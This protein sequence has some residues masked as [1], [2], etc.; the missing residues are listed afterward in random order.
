MEFG[1]GQALPIYSGGLGILAGDVLKTASDLGVPVIGIGLLYQQGYFRQIIS[2]DG[3]QR[4]FYPYNDPIQLPV[5][6][7]R[8]E[9]GEWLR[10]KLKYPGRS[11][12][13][14]TW[15]AKVGRVK[16]YL[17]DSN[18]PEN[19][20]ADRG[21]TAELYGGDAEKRLQQEIALGIGGWKLLHTLGSEPQVCHLNEGHA[22]L[23]VIERARSFMQ[24][25]GCEFEPALTVT[26]AG[27]IFTTHT[28][29]EAGFDRFPPPL[30][31]QYLGAY[32]EGLG[33]GL[34]GLLGLGRLDP[35]DDKE[36]FNMAYLAFHGA[37]RVNGVSRVH[38]EVSRRIF[39]VL[40]PRWP[41]VEVPVGH[42]TNGVHM[43]SWD[44]VEADSLWTETCGKHRWLGSMEKIADCFQ[45]VP[46]E[47]LWALRNAGRSQLVDYV[48]RRY[49]QQSRSSGASRESVSGSAGGIFNPQTLTLIRLLTN[50]KR[51]VQL[52]VA[53]KAHPHDEPAKRYIRE[54]QDFIKRPEVSG[55]V[56][57]LAD[58]DMLV[59]EQ[60]V[61]GVDVWINTPRCPLEA[62]GTSG[63][64][65]LINGG[66]NLSALDGWW[67][68]AYT[69]EV[70]WGFGGPRE[71]VDEAT[72]DRLDAEALYAILED[73]VVPAFYERNGSGIPTAWTKRMRQ[74]MA[75][76][77]P[78]FSSNRMMREYVQQYY[79]PA[80]EA[81]L[82]RAANDGARGFELARRLT[83]LSRTWTGL[84]FGKLTVTSQNGSHLFEVEVVCG[85]IDKADLLVELYAEDVQGKAPERWA[86]T[87]GEPVAAKQGS[88]LYRVSVP[89]SRPA[90][91]YTPRIVPHLAGLS[92]PLESALILWQHA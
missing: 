35:A 67:A 51:P 21:I 59:A 17:L 31:S 52:V 6:P 41:R 77:T 40:F 3:S 50:P 92:V 29:V 7:V 65:V 84:R 58:Y 68:E 38:G 76:L 70:G 4:E 78:Q 90:S 20:P 79:L 5:L 75:T 83:E 37:S 19:A 12:R 25:K 39:Q 2:A 73:R 61:Q 60:L 56:I 33:I 54:W 1:L 74:S 11:V 49:V 36:P 80:A 63:M 71:G 48:R 47:S 66:L 23:A 30:M 87:A 46:D 82:E 26:R 64:K 69:P 57:F 10:I 16:L 62:S 9:Q 44:A 34:Q 27:N 42:V 81:F 88:W 72:R 32:A 28:P 22:G 91:D 85:L 13:L 15:Q 8:N 24:A 14:R 53:G 18:D 55:R 86:M 43:P 45:R 89:A